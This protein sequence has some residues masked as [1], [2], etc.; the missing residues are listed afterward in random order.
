MVE[1]ASNWGL[2]GGKGLSRQDR[3]ERVFHAQHPSSFRVR[4]T[5]PFHNCFNYVN[6]VCPL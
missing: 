2:K 6:N 5:R 4:V 3:G 1:E